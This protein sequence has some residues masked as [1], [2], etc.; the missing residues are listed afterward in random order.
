MI[1]WKF[2]NCPIAFKSTEANLD[3]D[4]P[5]MAHA[6]HIDPTTKIIIIDGTPNNPLPADVSGG[7]GNTSSASQSAVSKR[8]KKTATNKS[9]TVQLPTVS[10]D[11]DDV[12][13]ESNYVEPTGDDSN[14]CWSGDWFDSQ[15][16]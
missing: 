9:E 12:N 8:S 6:N 7:N 15:R 14:T 1:T 3:R 11:L 13:S 5:K 16:V 10:S 2:E 4:I